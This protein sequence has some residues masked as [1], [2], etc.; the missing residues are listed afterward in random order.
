MYAVTLE[1]SDEKPIVI[2]RSMVSNNAVE[3]L[4]VVVQICRAEFQMV[5]PISLY[6]G[7]GVYRIFDIDNPHVYAKVSIIRDCN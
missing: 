2:N 7:H 1:S 4:P 6:M 3:I 5:N